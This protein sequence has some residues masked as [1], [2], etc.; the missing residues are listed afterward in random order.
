MRYHGGKSRVAGKL[1]PFLK[2]SLLRRRGLFVEPFMGGFNLVPPLYPEIR[3]AI[4]CDAHPG[5]AVL[6]RWVQVGNLPPEIDEAEYR[7][8]RSVGDWNDPMTTFAAFGCSYAGKEWGGFARSDDKRNYARES[9][10]S[11]RKKQATM[12]RVS[13]DSRNYRDLELRN[14]SATVYCDPPYRGTTSYGPAEATKFDPAEFDDWCEWTA[15]MGNDVF[16]SEFSAP[17]HW[18]VLLEIDRAVTMRRQNYGRKIER[19]YRVP[20]RRC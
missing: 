6:Y 17:T 5:L 9:I 11:L 19:L 20:K 2:E 18:D 3:W 4:C 1:V 7:R 16:V 12:A 10:E 13:F 15:G 14:T 8:L